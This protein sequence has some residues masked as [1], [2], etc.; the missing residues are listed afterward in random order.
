MMHTM[1]SAISFIVGGCPSVAPARNRLWGGDNGVGGWVIDQC[2][3]GTSW[4]RSESVE[5]CWPHVY[6]RGW[7]WYSSVLVAQT[8]LE[9]YV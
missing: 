2:G 4:R 3:P 5:M 1:I 7:A 8:G 6:V 9:L